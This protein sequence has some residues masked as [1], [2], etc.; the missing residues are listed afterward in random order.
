MNVQE[1]SP[2]ESMSLPS[3]SAASAPLA[4][5]ASVRALCRPISPITIIIEDDSDE[6]ECGYVG[7]VNHIIILD[8][9]SEL[10]LESLAAQMSSEGSVT[11]FDE[12]DIE[13]MKERVSLYAQI[14][15]VKSAKQWAVAEANR[16]LGYNGLSSRSK[17]RQ[18]KDARNRHAFKEDAKTLLVENNFTR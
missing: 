8:S 18:E 5:H 2:T 4:S 7:G 14:E 3:H 6:S 10:P 13:K 17:R 15:A 9:D 1:H 11:E 16:C 12:S